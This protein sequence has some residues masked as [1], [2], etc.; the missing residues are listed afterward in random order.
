MPRP[1]NPLSKRNESKLFTGADVARAVAREVERLGASKRARVVRQGGEFDDRAL[2]SIVKPPLIP[3]SAYS[4]S[5][6]D[7]VKAREAQMAGRFRMPARLAE[8]FGADDALFTAR[9][10]RLSPVQALSI[11][12]QAGRGPKADVIASEAQALFG[13]AGIAIGSETERSIRQHLADHGVAFAA[14]SW[15][16]R[17]DGSRLDPLLTAWPIEFVW[18]HPTDDCYVTQLRHFD[19]DPEL[20]PSMSQ[21][22]PVA[23]SVPIER[24]IHGNGRWIVFRKS[25]V[26]PHRMDA[27]VLPA[28]LV[29]ASH[30]FAMRDWRKGSSA[31]G[32]PK[33]VGQLPEGTALTDEA[34]ALTTDAAAFLQLVSAVASQDQPVG[35]KPFGSSIDYITNP[36]RAWEVWKE[37]ADKAEK[38]AA[39]IYLGTDGILGAQGGAPGVDV[40]ALFGV[41]TGE[42]QSDLAA[43]GR[44]IQSGLISPWAALNFGD[45][46]QAP[47]RSYVFPDPDESAVRED[48]AKRNAAFLSDVQQYRAAGF[49]V[50]Q[51]LVAKVAN[52][53]GVP[54]PMLPAAPAA[55]VTPAPVGGAPATP[56][57]P[58]GEA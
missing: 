50:D 46:K 33:V 26:L 49:V 24:I 18:W 52:A 19:E 54:V 35:I 38:A 28:S 5:I 30:A 13:S 58:T 15:V 9:K 22:A 20:S 17:A 36:S 3:P 47:T 34:G 55:P 43:I 48:F 8:S 12:I 45:D 23:T 57:T 56:P 10:V 7:I 1:R 53:H 2:R 29:W 51:A 31:H 6:E 14:V 32:N 44:G 11:D 16:P 25:E 4:W 42:I 37:L 27:A 41:A 40:Q 39:R 21:P